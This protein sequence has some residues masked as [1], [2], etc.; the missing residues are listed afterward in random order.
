M[1]IIAIVLIVAIV[2][3][4]VTKNLLFFEETHH[5]FVTNFLCSLLCLYICVPRI[6]PFLSL[7]CYRRKINPFYSLLCPCILLKEKKT[8]SALIA[9][10]LCEVSKAGWQGK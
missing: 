3:D 2:I 8:L 4:I 10:F 9:V 7:G 6:I 1:I 5:L